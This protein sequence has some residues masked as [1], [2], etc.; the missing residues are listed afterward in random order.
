MSPNGPG[1]VKTQNASR[2]DQYW[3]TQVACKQSR[4][5]LVVNVYIKDFYGSGIF[6]P[7][8]AWE[9]H[10]TPGFV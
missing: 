9:M 10:K 2:Y 4:R 5:Y 7:N 6:S 8:K 3:L 1:R